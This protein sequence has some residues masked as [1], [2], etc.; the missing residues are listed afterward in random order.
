M[1]TVTSTQ[2]TPAN[3][4][5]SKMSTM[6]PFAMRASEKEFEDFEL[7]PPGLHPAVLVSMI[8]LG[9]HSF[10]YQ[11]KTN[12]L[13]KVFLVWELTGEFDS[14]GNPFLVKQDYTLSLG[15]KANFRRMLEA[16][17]GRSFGPDEDF[18][19]L[20]LLGK[21]CVVNLSLGTNKDG[22]KKFI[23]VTGVSAPMKGQAVPP[24]SHKPFVWH[25]SQAEPGN[26]PPIPEWVPR[27]YGRLVADDIKKSKEWP[28]IGQKTN[29]Q[30]VADMLDN[31][32]KGPNV[33]VDDDN[34]P[35]F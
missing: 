19:A 5:E 6:S 33:P 16:W 9:T 22:S 7:P 30:I 3:A 10:E 1:S 26:D 29:G 27:N 8:D 31:P 32:Q 18:D 25:M 17:A 14:G 15:K 23:E 11:G 20:V 35:A 2:Q 28:L 21:P 13:R 24:A 12:E 34:K 4:K